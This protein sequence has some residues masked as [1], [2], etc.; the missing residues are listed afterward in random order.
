[1]STD[2]EPKIRVPEA[3]FRRRSSDE[4]A[5]DKK[6]KDL[7]TEAHLTVAAIRVLEHRQDTPPSIEA[8]GELLSYSTEHANLIC[9]KLSQAGVLKIAQGPFGTRLFIQDHQLLETLPK[10]ETG[11]ALKDALE[12]FQASRKD[13][14]SRIESIKAKQAQKQ[15]DLFAQLDQKLKGDLNKDR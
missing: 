6:P 9:K 15:K 11:D 7:Y 10:E 13:Y 3:F 2:G 8:V 14:D 4:T 5:M 12:A 1:M